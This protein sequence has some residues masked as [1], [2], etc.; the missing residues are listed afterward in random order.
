MLVKK[1]TLKKLKSKKKKI[2]EVFK[3]GPPCLNKLA[4]TGFGEGSRNNALF[5]IAVYFK[6]ANPDNWEDEIVK[7]NIE[8]MNPPLSNN[9]VQ[10][11]IKSV[12]RKGYDKY[13]C[14]DSPI[15]SVC[16]SGLCRMKKYGVGFGEEEMPT[17][18]NL[19]KYAS[20]PPQWFLDVGEKR[21]EL[22]S[23]QLYMPGLLLWH[24]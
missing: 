12:N 5:N 6:Q 7:A 19:T 1:K 4:M 15:N 3:D 18:G 16:N 2:E 22:K 20:K 24:V 14:K 23:E 9:E 8:Y 10:Q 11:L 17:L 13:R 21:I